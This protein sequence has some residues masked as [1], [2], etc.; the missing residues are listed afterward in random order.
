MTRTGPESRL[1]VTGAAIASDD[2]P[3]PVESS[4][5]T[6]AGGGASEASA[7]SGDAGLVL[8]VV[9]NGLVVVFAS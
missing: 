9:D 5:A 3:M 7:D 2:G 4:R 8:F 1:A 6:A